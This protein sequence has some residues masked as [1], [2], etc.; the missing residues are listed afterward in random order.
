MD[1]M[2]W[3]EAEAFADPPLPWHSREEDDMTDF[4]SGDERMGL[5]DEL[6]KERCR[7]VWGIADDAAA[8]L[9][10]STCIV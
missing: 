8:D 7:P 4:R 5:H 10:C 2:H 9:L 6:D 1:F 3:V